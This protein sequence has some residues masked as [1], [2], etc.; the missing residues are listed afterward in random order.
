MLSLGLKP[1]RPWIVAKQPDS[2]LSARKPAAAS[3]SSSRGA[4]CIIRWRGLGRRAHA[5]RSAGS[6]VRK[7]PP[8]SP[9]RETKYATFSQQCRHF[10]FWFSNGV[11]RISRAYV[12]P[13]RPGGVPFPICRKQHAAL[14]RRDVT[15]VCAEGT[16]APARHGRCDGH[17]ECEQHHRSGVGSTMMR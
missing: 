17:R 14:R 7:C 10:R 16:M 5:A 2:G 3:G 6:P 8:P 13:D 15:R 1:G 11:H 12:V 4:F 9:A